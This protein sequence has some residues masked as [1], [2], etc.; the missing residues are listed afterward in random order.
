M[1]W[2]SARAALTTVGVLILVVLAGYWI[3]RSPEPS[4][5]LLALVVV[6]GGPVGWFWWKARRDDRARREAAAARPGR[7]T[8]AVWADEHLESALADLGA[9]AGGLPGGTR[10]TLAWSPS[11]VE[12]WRGRVVLTTL[13][14][15]QVAT[16][17][18]TIGRAASAGNPAV[19]LVTTEAVRLVLVPARHPDGGML[20]ARVAQVDALAIELEEA[21][22]PAADASRIP[23][24]PV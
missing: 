5:S 16:I 8:H 9:T 19:A 12:L 4:W 6:V 20:P 22:N 14:W 13:P 21:R 7:R 24:E 10:L 17:G 2:Q 23:P 15:T 1:T 18:R 3:A 11:G